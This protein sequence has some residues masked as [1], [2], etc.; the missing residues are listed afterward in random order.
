MPISQKQIDLSE[1]PARVFWKNVKR[2]PNGCWL[3][4]GRVNT[5]HNGTHFKGY[6]YGEFT[7]TD[8]RYIPIIKTRMAHR[9]ALFLTYG[10]E[11]PTTHDVFPMVCGDHLCVNPEHLGIK[12]RFTS[13]SMPATEFFDALVAQMKEAA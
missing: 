13:R 6:A 11:V 4:A 7:L 12:E 10:I 5:N 1:G 2:Q 8:S 3:W 9:I